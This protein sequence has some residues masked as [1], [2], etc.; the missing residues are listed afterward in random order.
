MNNRSDGGNEDFIVKEIVPPVFERQE[1]IVTN[2]PEGSRKRKRGIEQ[3]N[4]IMS[5]CDLLPLQQ[6]VLCKQ[7]E[8]IS[9]QLQLIEEQGSNNYRLKKQRLLQRDQF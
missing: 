6:E 4:H 7:M 8:V 1:V 3:P 5:A 9:A 2:R